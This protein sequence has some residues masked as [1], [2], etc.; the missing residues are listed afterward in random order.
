[1]GST[2]KISAESSRI[3]PPPSLHCSCA[4]LAWTL[5]LIVHQLSLLQLSLTDMTAEFLNFSRNR[6]FSRNS[7]LKNS[8]SVE[9]TRYHNSAVQSN[10]SSLCTHI[11]Y[12][13]VTDVYHH[14]WSETNVA[15]LLLSCMGA[16]SWPSWLPCLQNTSPHFKN[17]HVIADAPQFASTLL[18]KLII[19]GYDIK[20]K[21][22]W[23]DLLCHHT[24]SCIMH[25]SQAT[26]LLRKSRLPYSLLP[27][28]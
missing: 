20:K 19:S 7:F 8:R 26:K 4:S 23:N 28:C 13:C 27:C 25:A 24:V 17:V 18:Y 11:A 21:K 14:N 5:M 16:K 6:C 12:R 15:C 1:M 22:S 9:K 10:K 3:A 2:R